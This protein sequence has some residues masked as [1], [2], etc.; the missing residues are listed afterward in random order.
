MPVAS[1]LAATGPERLN[2][3]GPFDALLPWGGLRRGETVAVTGS[4]SL[5]LALVSRASREGAWCAAIDLPTLGLAAAREAGVDLDRF[6]IVPFAGDR[7]PEVVS[8][9]VDAVDVV[10]LGL[11]GPVPSS[12]TR[13]LQERVRRHGAVLLTLQGPKVPVWERTPLQLTVVRQQAEGLGDGHGYLRRRHLEVRAEG[14][15]AAAQPR[16]VHLAIPPPRPVET[17]AAQGSNIESANPTTAGTA[18]EAG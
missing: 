3:D 11:T 8:G 18:R 10:L 1:R 17:S 6:L 5:A 12:T 4:G 2:V 14:R 7:W 16:T 9:L 13:R 15:G